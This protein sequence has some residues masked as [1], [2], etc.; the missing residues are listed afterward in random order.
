RNDFFPA[1]T[2]TF[3]LVAFS[4]KVFLTLWLLFIA[5][6]VHLYA[7]S[8]SN[9]TYF[10]PSNISKQYARLHNNFRERA[11]PTA[12][13]MNFVTLSATL[14][15]LATVRAKRRTVNK[16]FKSLG[17]YKGLDQN[18]YLGP[19]MDPKEIMNQ[20]FSEVDNFVANFSLSPRPR[21]C[22]RNCSCMHYANIMSSELTQIG[23]GVSRCKNDTFLTVCLYSHY[24]NGQ[25]IYKTGRPCSECPPDKPFC[26]DDLC[27]S[28]ELALSPETS[29]TYGVNMKERLECKLTC[30]NCGQLVSVLTGPKLKCQCN[31]QDAYGTGHLCQDR[32]ARLPKQNCEP[33]SPRPS[34]LNGGKVG[35]KSD[36]TCICP[37]GFSGQRCELD[38]NRWNNS[39]SMSLKSVENQFKQISAP[40][41]GMFHSTIWPMLQSQIASF[42]TAECEVNATH[43]ALCCS[44][45]AADFGKPR[46]EI[47]P[48][49]VR[50][51]R[52]SVERNCDGSLHFTFGV[53]ATD[54]SSSLCELS[55]TAAAKAA[56]A[57]ASSGTTAKYIPLSYLLPAV[58]KRHRG[59]NGQLLSHK[60]GV[61]IQSID[62]AKEPDVHDFNRNS[63]KTA[64]DTGGQC[65][66]PVQSRSQALTAPGTVIA[67]TL[68]CTLSASFFL[69]FVRIFF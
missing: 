24:Y 47:K 58:K 34:C 50:L 25:V 41:K 44:R 16:N 43:L 52:S 13:A 15:A 28:S 55:L 57:G 17:E 30:Q 38:E 36:C 64:G 6:N 27:V 21:Y 23:C 4:A 35:P 5:Q 45:D 65:L 40:T 32:N 1:S 39:I 8:G 37:D 19:T 62:P 22:R 29:K 18:V 51:N 61:V 3:I 33:C 10:F 68:A 11:L 2:M 42:M 67:C 46:G 9:A 49:G 48:T 60:R 12:R 63:S 54:S 20:W 31:C 59:L 69:N 53:V 14:E 56:G 26:F 66:K 7:T